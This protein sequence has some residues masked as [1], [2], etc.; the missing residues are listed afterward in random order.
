MKVRKGGIVRKEAKDGEIS[1]LKDKIRRL[2]SDKRKLISE[3]KTL[4]AALLENLKFMK[5]STK[6][7]SVEDLIKGAK[8][9]QT[10]KEVKD[11]LDC[12]DCGNKLSVL[13]IGNDGGKS[14]TCK[15]GYRRKE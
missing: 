8:K 12:P 15:C 2:E 1:K 4:E 3:V 5:G 10:L 7:V 6:D 13:I 9:K 14:L 11:G